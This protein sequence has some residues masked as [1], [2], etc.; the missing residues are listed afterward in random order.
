MMVRRFLHPLLA[1]WIIYGENLEFTPILGAINDINDTI[2]HHVLM[3]SEFKENITAASVGNLCSGYK[4]FN[5]HLGCHNEIKILHNVIFKSGKI[6]INSPESYISTDNQKMML[7][8]RAQ[9]I[10]I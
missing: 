1:L 8:C 4:S 3:S 9:K 2:Q 7:C 10:G 5:F 6:V